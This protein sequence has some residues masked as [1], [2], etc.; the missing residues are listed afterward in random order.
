MKRVGKPWFFVVALLIA[1]LAYFTFFGLYGTNENGESVTYVRGVKDIRWGTD[2]QGGVSVTFGPAEGI[3]ATEMQMDAVEETLNNRLVANNVTDYE[4]YVDTGSD[5]IM[6][7]F[8]WKDGET[9]DVEGTIDELS[10]TAQL[11]FVEGIPDYIAAMYLDDA[12]NIVQVEDSAG[13]LYNVSVEGKHVDKAQVVQDQMTGQ[14]AV[15]LDFTAEGTEKF[16][17]STER[18][19]GNYISIWMDGALLSAPTVESVISDGKAQITSTGGFTAEDV[20]TLVN[21]INSGA[22]PFTLETKDYDVVDPTLGKDSLKAMMIAGLIAFALICIFMIAYYRLP[23]FVACIALLGQ[24]AGSLAMVSGLFPIFDSFTLTLPGIAGIILSIGM[25]VDANIITSERIREEIRKGK[26]I[27]GSIDSGNENSFSSIFDG[28]ITVIIVAV[29]LMGVFGPPDS[30]WSKLLTP[31]LWMFP[32]ATTGAIYSFGYTLLVGVIFNFLMGVTASRLM[33]KALS[34]FKIFRKRWMY[35][36][37][38][39]K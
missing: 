20:T 22:L 29:I 21:N 31:F 27:D 39:E 23:G 30:L 4:L 7:S 6:V 34:R 14:Y 35:G 24:A 8:P 37:A 9:Q 38:D 10:A 17:Q 32:T 36:G 3:D 15:S 11:L 12:G 33:L 26:T 5:R 13:N 16:A 19:L 2:I 28:N 1:A 25:G 18:Q